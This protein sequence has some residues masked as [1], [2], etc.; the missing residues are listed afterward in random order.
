MSQETMGAVGGT[1]WE[2]RKRLKRAV[3]YAT[4]VFMSLLYVFPVYWFTKSAFQSRESLFQSSIAYVPTDPTLANIRGLLVDSAFITYFQNSVVV[5]IG[6]ILVTLIS[7][8][9]AGYTLTRIELPGKKQVANITVFSYMYPPIL[10]VMPMFLL[11]FAIGMT[12][13]YIGLVLA[14]SALTLPFSIWLMWQFFETIPI[15]HEESA[16]IYGAGRIRGFLEIALPMAKPGFIAVGIYAF[17]VSWNDFTMANI[18]M[19]APPK[20]TLP[21]GMMTFLQAQSTDWGAIMAASFF[22]A[23]PPFLLVYGMQRY[24][25][26]GFQLT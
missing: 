12:N 6:V 19:Q 9:L 5:A 4:M 20:R 16:W 24:L 8:T 18:L 7:S 15:S 13:T 21:V 1:D 25:L 22:I 10:L 3:L 17:A 14:Q 23:I 26:R 11:W 2:R